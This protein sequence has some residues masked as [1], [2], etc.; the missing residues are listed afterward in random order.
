MKRAASLLTLLVLASASVFGQKIKY[1]DLFVLLDSKRY[2]DAEPFLRKYLKENDDNP[3]AQLFMGFILQEK[4]LRA[5]VLK[6]TE[7]V[8]QNADSA[9]IYMDLAHKGITEKEIKRNDEYYQSYSRRDQRTGEYGI[10]MS[11]VHLDI[12]RRVLELKSRKD[13]VKALRGQFVAWER[14]YQASAVGFKAIQEAFPGEKELLLQSDPKVIDDLKA[15]KVNFDSCTLMFAAYKTT[16]SHL[17]KTAYNQMFDA[18]KIVKFKEEG[19]GLPDF[20]ADDLKTWNYDE[21]ASA[22]LNEIHNEVQPFRDKLVAYDVEINKLVDKVKK[23]S[24]SVT[25]ELR[26]VEEKIRTNPVARFDASPMPLLIF[27]MKLE[28]LRFASTH[29]DNRRQRDSASLVVRLNAIKSE[30]TTLKKLDSIAG[31]LAAKDIEKETINYQHF[32]TNSYGSTTTLKNLISATKEFAE[33]EKHKREDIVASLSNSLN[34]LLVDSDSVSLGTVKQK[35]PSHFPLATLPEKFTSGVKYGADSVATGFFYTITPNRVP[36]V[37][38]S[39]TVDKVSFGKRNL[40]VLKGIVTSNDAGNVYYSMIYSETK[41]GDKFPVTIA[42][43]NKPEGLAWTSNYKFDFLPSE[44]IFS[45][46]TGGLSVKI[47]S[48]GGESKLI[49]LDKNGKQL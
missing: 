13:N 5:D 14:L 49:V 20:Y 46:D 40:P 29:I 30:L 34:W 19:K 24:T 15:I 27:R 4:C 2:D 47:T 12:E 38:V 16:L 39:F 45:P 33:H 48:P 21:W 3:N 6:E 35:R 10:K 32:V 42:R 26:G 9:V 23:D 17:G 31:M 25:T 22:A 44:L 11:D 1:K 37:K 7:K 36:D 8:A 43:I 28:E 18:K 41:T